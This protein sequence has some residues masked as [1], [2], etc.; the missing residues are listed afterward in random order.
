MSRDRF[1][2]VARTR[3][4]RW[5]R[6]RRPVM[7][8][9]RLLTVARM[10]AIPVLIV[11]LWQIWGTNLPEDSNVPVPSEVVE[12]A[13]FLISS[14]DLQ[15]AV[16]IS[17]RRV[18]SGFLIAL[19]IGV[20]V[21][22]LMGMLRP[23]ER[24]ADPVVHTFRMIAPIALVPLAIVWFG[25]RG[26]AAIFIVAYGAVFP[27]ILNTINGVKEVDR[28]LVKASRTMGLRTL[29]ILRRVILPGALPSVYTGVRIAMGM[30]WGAIIAAEL[31]VGFKAYPSAEGVGLRSGAGGGI[32]FMMFFLYDN[33]VATDL[34]VVTIIAV[35]AVAFASDR[36]LRY[37][38]RKA[39]PWARL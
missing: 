30:A 25:P 14:G 11:V 15:L 37:V 7:S 26:T 27:V 18:L 21:G 4:N 35:G 12:G 31:T 29:K 22:L 6:Y 5:W 20:P 13:V 16:W 2:R 32:G 17:L 28:L 34:I 23:V 8:R 3:R 38:A 10:A 9:D 39:M 1:L 19:A 24:N 33:R 36:V